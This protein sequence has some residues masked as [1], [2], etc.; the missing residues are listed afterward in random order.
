MRRV[1]QPDFEVLLYNGFYKRGFLPADVQQLSTSAIALPHS[2]QIS[3][4]N[5]DRHQHEERIGHGTPGTFS[6]E[7]LG[8]SLLCVIGRW[9]TRSI[10][11]KE[12]LGC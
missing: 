9:Y 10:T 2:S 6:W 8:I 1:A 7:F 3:T 5:L 12:H 11:Q 4:M